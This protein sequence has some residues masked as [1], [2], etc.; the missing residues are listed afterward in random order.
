LYNPGNSSAFFKFLLTKDK[1]FAP[2]VL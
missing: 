2:K 1:L